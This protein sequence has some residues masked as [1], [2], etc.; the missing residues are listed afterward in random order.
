MSRKK[1]NLYLV[2]LLIVMYL[3]CLLVSYKSAV[4]YVESDFRQSVKSVKDYFEKNYCQR[5]NEGEYISLES[6]TYDF[7]TEAEHKYP[8]QAAFV[9]P[10]VRVKEKTGRQKK[11]ENCDSK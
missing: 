11:Y 3:A 5:A 2:V 6:I 7:Y 1:M 4:N 10:E 9:D 8:W